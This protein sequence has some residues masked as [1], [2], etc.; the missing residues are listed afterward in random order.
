MKIFML[1]VFYHNKKIVKK[2]N[3]AKVE[4]KKIVRERYTIPGMEET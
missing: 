1:G 4:N 2:F 3:N